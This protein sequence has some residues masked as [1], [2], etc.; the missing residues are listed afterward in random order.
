MKSLRELAA[1]EKLRVAIAES[2]TGG[3]VSAELVREAGA[4]DFFLGS[5]IA[6]QDEIKIATLGVSPSVIHSQ[7][8]VDPEVAIQMAQGVR[9]KFARQCLVDY[10]LVFGIS[11]TGVAGPDSVGSNQPGLVYFGVSSAK[12]EQVVVEEFSGT[13]DEVRLAAT[14]RA[15]E[16]IRE[17][18][19]AL[20]G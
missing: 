13:R 6:Y 3:L 1:N 8:S 16:L 10:D 12:V 20:A 15:I 7:T 4:S 9:S 17:Q 19:T 2:L 18:L 5:V 11:T 14:N